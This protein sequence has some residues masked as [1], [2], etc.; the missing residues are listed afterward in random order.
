MSYYRI[1]NLT[2]L[3]YIYNRFIK[4]GVR[5][6][7]KTFLKPKFIRSRIFF[8]SFNQL[9]NHPP[10]HSVC[11]CVCGV[12][13]KSK[14]KK[15]KKWIL[16]SMS[17]NY[18]SCGGN[19]SS[20]IVDCITLAFFLFFVT[21]FNIWLHRNSVLAGIRGRDDDLIQC[22]HASYIFSS[23]YLSYSK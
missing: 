12:H 8:Y 18:S 6:K 15:K 1:V 22:I 14:A 9:T 5:T 7:R 21:K 16:Y 2:D 4:G 3:T 11:V 13:L 23:S 19:N 10:T 20:G 17:N